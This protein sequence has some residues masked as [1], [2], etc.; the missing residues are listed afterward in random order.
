VQRTLLF[1]ATGILTLSLIAL[2]I[3]VDPHSGS[4]M[5]AAAM[6]KNSGNGGGHGNSG[7]SGGGASNG[8]S[9]GA[10]NGN[11]GGASNGN[12]GGAGSNGNAGA[13]GSN[14]NS[15]GSNPAGADD[16]AS[17]SASTA[18]SA[19]TGAAADSAPALA[20]ARQQLDE[21]QAEL[22]AAQRALST[23]VGDGDDTKIAIA[24]GRVAGAQ[25]AVS[26]AEMNVA[27]ARAGVTDLGIVADSQ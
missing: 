2:P 8:N 26:S 7:G 3:T 11:S 24:R 9:G 1:A 17:D 5:T 20:Q 21:A 16:A 22:A 10:S 25:Y 19:N 18:G 4:L 23:T 12:S 15:G 6:A 27:A 13:A 14:G